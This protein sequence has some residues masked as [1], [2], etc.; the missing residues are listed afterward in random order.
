MDPRVVP[1]PEHPPRHD[2]VD[3][4]RGALVLATKAV[5]VLLHRQK[6][7]LILL[8]QEVAELPIVWWG[9]DLLW[10]HWSQASFLGGGRARHP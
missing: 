6:V 1:E 7:S 4:L 8:V 10:G 5:Q 3:L 2:L 9:P